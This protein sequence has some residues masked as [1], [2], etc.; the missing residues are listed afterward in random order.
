M[1]F[2]SDEYEQFYE[3]LNCVKW[4]NMQAEQYSSPTFFDSIFSVLN[5]TYC[6]SLSGSQ[7]ISDIQLSPSGRSRCGELQKKCLLLCKWFALWTDF[8]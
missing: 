4:K 7:S 1:T 2:S 3:E 5:N 6:L 8:T